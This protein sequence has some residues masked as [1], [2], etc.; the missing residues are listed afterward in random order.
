[1]AGGSIGLCDLR[2]IPKPQRALRSTT[3][4]LPFFSVVRQ[5]DYLEVRGTDNWL[6]YCNHNQLTRLLINQL[7]RLLISRLFEVM[8]VFYVVTR[9][10]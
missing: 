5:S 6:H 1:M 3:T 2:G 10:L 4:C 8:I 7:T 9:Q